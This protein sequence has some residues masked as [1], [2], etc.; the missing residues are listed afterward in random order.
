MSPRFPNVKK[1]RSLLRLL[2]FLCLLLT[3]WSINDRLKLKKGLFGI[4]RKEEKRNE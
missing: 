1:A 4:D 2:V 3:M